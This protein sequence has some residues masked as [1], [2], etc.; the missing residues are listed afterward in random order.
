MKELLGMHSANIA[1]CIGLPGALTGDPQVTYRISGMILRGAVYPP[2][3]FRIS[4]FDERGCRP[5]I[6]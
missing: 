3:A 1:E 4:D 6:I 2:V 5:I